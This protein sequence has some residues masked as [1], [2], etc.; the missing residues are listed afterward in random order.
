[1]AL[2]LHHGGQG[3]VEEWEG[4][5]GAGAGGDRVKAA[6]YPSGQRGQAVGPLREM[7]RE[8]L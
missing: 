2:K 6:A 7:A 4:G 1:M 5:E 3:R 8:A